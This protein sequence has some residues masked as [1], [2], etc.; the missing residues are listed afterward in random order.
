MIP[1]DQ[2]LDVTPTDESGE[3]DLSLIEYS[4]SLTP[5]ERVERHYQAR[6]F[7]QQLREAGRKL[8]GPHG[9]VD[10]NPRPAE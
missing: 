10:P 8:H 6:R 4:L 2:P 7:V 5:T 9:P 1:P 3:V